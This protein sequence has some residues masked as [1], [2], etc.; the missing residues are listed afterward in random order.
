M[1][2]TIM[3][4]LL[5]LFFVVVVSAIGIYFLA[6]KPPEPQSVFEKGIEVVVGMFGWYVVN[7]ITWFLFLPPSRSSLQGGYGA[8]IDIF[9]LG[10]IPFNIIFLMILGSI[11]RTRMIA[12]GILMALALN[13]LI[14][15]LLGMTMNAFCFIPF[16]DK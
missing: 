4:V 10:L 2:P 3:N 14:S 16:F 13:F 5:F 12:L 11:P 1:Q 9:S 7:G 6:K 15:L 8:E